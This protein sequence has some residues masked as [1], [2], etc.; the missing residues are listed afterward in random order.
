MTPTPTP[1]IT[2]TPIPTLLSSTLYGWGQAS[3]TIGLDPGQAPAPITTPINVFDKLWY[4]I[5]VGNGALGITTDGKLWSWG[6]G[7][8]GNGISPAL[9]NSSA[10]KEVSVGNLVFLAIKSDG[11]LWSWGV[12]DYDQLGD[13]TGVDKSSPVK[14]GNS[15]WSKIFASN[16]HCLGIKTDGTLWGWGSNGEGELGV[17]FTSYSVNTPIQIGSDRDWLNLSE[18][19][20]FGQS[21]AIKNDKSLWGWGYNPH[22]SI[23]DNTTSSRSSPVKIGDKKWKSISAGDSYHTVGLD[24]SGYL[25]TWGSNQF[26]KLGDGTTTDKSSPVKIGNNKWYSAFGISNN[27]IAMDNY[28]RLW[29]WGDNRNGELG[30]GTSGL[31]TEKSLPVLVGGSKW[32]Y[33]CGGNG[34]ILALKS[35]CFQVDPKLGWQD[36]GVFVY[37]TLIVNATGN[38]NAHDPPGA[39][40]D[41][42]TPD[43]L[44]KYLESNFIPYSQLPCNHEAL[45]G[46]IGVTGDPFFIG[47]NFYSSSLQTGKLYLAT[48]DSARSDNTGF[49]YACMLAP[50]PPPTPTPTIAP[51]PTS[52]PVPPTT[53]TSTPI[54]PTPTPI[55]PTPTPTNAPPNCPDRVIVIEVCDSNAAKDDNISITLNGTVIANELDFSRNEANQH[56]TYCSLY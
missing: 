13:G 4:K 54:P 18:N 21:F 6:N 35:N 9:V 38:V 25:Y 52:T 55:R 22:G 15:T 10:W 20:G 23:G 49:F 46:K 29:T 17:G 47:S 42:S 36:S 24:E 14:I 37:G 43:G 27:T 19:G 3:L 5:S 41:D 45:I 2:P 32:I 8:I 50:P 39:I 56:Y 30:I 7:A 11:S 53:P 31:N 1:T 12:N 40:L 48:N 28:S 33:A 44:D 51:T 34:N 26:G 16:S